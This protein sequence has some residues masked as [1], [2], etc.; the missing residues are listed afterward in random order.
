M[1]ITLLSDFGLRDP[2]VGIMKGVILSRAPGVRL[3]D[4]THEIPP[5][6]IRA[7]GLALRQAVPYFPRGTIHL[8]VVDPG[9]GS[10]RRILAAQAH[11]QFF[12]APDNGL[13]SPILAGDPQTRAVSAERPDLCLPGTCGTFHGRDILAPLAA[14]L[15]GGQTLEELGP[16][17]G[18]WATFALPA[19]QVT[20]GEVRGEISFSDRFGNLT[21]NIEPRHLEQ[22]RL[23]PGQAAVHLGGVFLAG[24]STHYAAVATGQAVALFNS[25]GALEIAVRNGNAAA[26]LNQRAGDLVTVT[27]LGQ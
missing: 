9:V 19:P 6:D 14:A 1:I 11:E 15:A 4:L 17:V 25:S 24:I 7:G 21:T 26:A 22:A 2:F 23:R 20:L 16:A 8:A 10:A 18:D 12:V 3:V 13:L 27:R 5:Q